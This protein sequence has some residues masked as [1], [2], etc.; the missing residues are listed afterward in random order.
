M[1]RFSSS[2]PDSLTLQE[3]LAPER[4]TEELE[5]LLNR[6]LIHPVADFLGHPGKNLRPLLVKLGYL[7]SLEEE[8]EITPEVEMKL[9]QASAIVE[10][11]HNGSLIV[12]DIQDGSELR[13]NKPSMHVKHGMPL[14]LNAGN[15]LYFR[16]LSLVRKLDLPALDAFELLDDLIH[17]MEK[18]HLGQALDLGTSIHKLSQDQVMSTSLTSMELKTGTLL[19]LALRLGMAVSG[20]T[21][22]KN[23]ILEIGRRAGLLLQ[24]FDDLGNFLT[25]GEK[26]FEDLYNKRP[27]WVW[28]LASE[29][30]SELYENFCLC[31]DKLP[32]TRLLTAWSDELRFQ[33]LIQLRTQSEVNEFFTIFNKNFGLS[34]PQSLSL[35]THFNAI[36][37][38]SYVKKT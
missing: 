23:E 20:N 21:T 10:L 32:D 16:A 26:Q 11:I 7:L 29:L 35:I 5:N 18:A 8:S 15:W 3:H 37:E 19:S 27:T 6:N 34:H 12:D 36:L 4:Y 1:N 30:H 24:M 2:L 22:R 14:A 25:P 17:L 31:V 33:Q 13:R 38:N 9:T 28:G